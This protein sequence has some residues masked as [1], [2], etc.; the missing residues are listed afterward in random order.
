[1]LCPLATALTGPEA[2]LR[3][4]R[5]HWV[6]VL[7]A[8]LGGVLKSESFALSQSFYFGPITGRPQPEIVR[9][10]GKC[11]DQLA[12]APAPK[13]PANGAGE[14]QLAAPVQT[15]DGDVGE[16]RSADL[17]GRMC[18]DARGK[19]ADYEILAKHRE[20]PKV[21]QLAPEARDRYLRHTLARVRSKLRI[22]EAP[23]TEDGEPEAELPARD[24]LNFRELQ[25]Q[26]PPERKWIL[27]QWIPRGH[28]TLLTGRGGMGKSL[29]IQAVG[30]ALALR[31]EYIGHVPQPYRVLYWAGED[32]RDELWR[33]QLNICN[34]LD[35][36]LAALDGLLVLQSFL[37]RDMTLAAPVYGALLPTPLMGELREQVGDYK[38]DFVILDT[39][40][41]V[42]GGNENDRHSVTT[43]LS[44]LQGACG[45]AT[46][47]L[48]AHPA[49]AEG[50]EFSGSTAWEG[51]VRARLFL[52]NKLPQEGKRERE[53]DEGESLDPRVRYLMR[54]KANYADVNDIVELEYSDGVLVPEEPLDAPARTLAAPTEEECCAVV[55]AAVR[56]LTQIGQYGN[57]SK[58]TPAYLPKLAKRFNLLGRLSE[59]RFEAA[60]T[61]LMLRQEL[62]SAV[63]G[64]YSNRT[65]RHGLV[66]AE[67]GPS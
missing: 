30:T 21:A 25:D 44:W 8:I 10:E 58:S 18:R 50:S 4:Q 36:S 11:I 27:S 16:D 39:A 7:N 51:S 19:L 12:D 57:S 14:E 54:R 35:V 33:R 31:R 17:Y 34:Y 26:Q 45:E 56:Q 9:L 38:A 49:K 20:H 15:D 42:Y 5:R 23:L 22:K 24:P 40:A 1:V 66:L 60:M 67:G 52:T 43:F 13:F 53:D 2:E 62:K 47:C 65:D 48:L 63:I 37:G 3:Q 61:T 59:K 32:D 6:G 46:P 55:R 28:P 41:R 64:R 29:L